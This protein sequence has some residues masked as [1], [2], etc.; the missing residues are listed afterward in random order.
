MGGGGFSMEPENLALDQWLLSLVAAD[1]PRV[2]F[3]PT[4][5]GD[6]DGYIRKFYATYSRLRCNPDHLSLFR[7]DADDLGHVLLQQDIIYVGGG[8]T[9]NMLAIWRAH[10]LD[11]ILRKAW[12][13]GVILAG[14][15][16]GSL[17]WYESGLTD[18]LGTELAPLHD[19]LGLLPGSHCPHYDGE[20]LRRPAYRR[21]VQAGELPA[22]IAADDGVALLYEDRELVDVV[23][24]RP[25]RS[26]WRV[27]PGDDDGVEVC[28]EAR[29]LPSE[30]KTTPFQGGCH[31]GQVLWEI[32]VD[33]RAETVLDCNCSICRKKGFLHLIVEPEDFRLIKGERHLEE[34]RFNTGKAAHKFC[35]ACGIHSFYVPRSHP[36]KID[37]NVRCIDGVDLAEL[38]IEPFDGARW[39]ENVDDIR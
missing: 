21:L 6:A 22:G 18:S 13:Q 28:V 23:T 24:S 14:L 30:E 29:P 9:A 15:S 1:R 38:S 39:E 32:D 31:C 20:E 3:L 5:S 33:P 36:D 19:G 7:R 4:A 37:V 27:T 11:K 17:C 26:A 16:A 35:T 8:N 10:G 34:Y 2:C 12:A 25:G